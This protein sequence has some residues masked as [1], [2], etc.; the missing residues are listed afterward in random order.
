MHEFRTTQVIQVM[1]TMATAF[2]FRS[3]RIRVV[4]G[5]VAGHKM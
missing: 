5:V 4:A 3:N 1:K 2:G